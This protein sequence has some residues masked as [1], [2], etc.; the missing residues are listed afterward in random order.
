MIS[1]AP[2]PEAGGRTFQ[3]PV[4]HV[5][6]LTGLNF[7]ALRDVQAGGVASFAPARRSSGSLAISATSLW[8]DD[9]VA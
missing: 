1:F 4:A 6:E 8:T 2:G 9:P 5:E 3:T 7:G